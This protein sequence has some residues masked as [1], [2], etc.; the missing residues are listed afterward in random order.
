MRV[1]TVL[2]KKIKNTSFCSASSE[3]VRFSTRGFTVKLENVNKPSLG[4]FKIDFQWL[5]NAKE[6][7]AYVQKLRQRTQFGGGVNIFPPACKF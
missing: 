5:L 4:L 1:Q 2:L 3:K 6:E 7:M